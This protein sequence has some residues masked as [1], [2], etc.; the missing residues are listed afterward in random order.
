MLGGSLSCMTS[1]L[2]SHASYHPSVTHCVPSTL[3][4]LRNHLM[5]S[6]HF[7]YLIDEENAFGGP[8]AL[9]CRK[10]ALA[11]ELSLKAGALPSRSLLSAP[12]RSRAPFSPLSTLCDTHAPGPASA[13]PSSVPGTAFVP[14]RCRDL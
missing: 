13:R 1:Y 5:L 9:S 14:L 10:E 8:V 4:N 11:F 2:H 7:V 3:S 6:M 12:P